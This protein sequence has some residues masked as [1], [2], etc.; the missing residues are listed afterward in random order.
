[1]LGT[2]L[3]IQPLSCNLL[4]NF[5]EFQPLPAKTYTDIYGPAPPS[6]TRDAKI[7]KP[8]ITADAKIMK[9]LI[10]YYLVYVPSRT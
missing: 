4:G 9:A 1:M 5:L 10:P 3:E 7:M 8:L 6:Q 2:F